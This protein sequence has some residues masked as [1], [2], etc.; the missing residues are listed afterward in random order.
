M[1]GFSPRAFCLPVALFVLACS[2][3]KQQSANLISP[4]I[5]IQQISATPTAARHVSG[6]LPVAFRVEVFNNSG[7]PLTLTR[8]R[9]ESVGEGAYNLLSSSQ[10]FDARI[11][12]D[13]GVS[14]EFWTSA[15]GQN[16]IMGN[17]GPVTIRGIAYFD[18]PVGAFQKIFI[19]Q[20]NDIGRGGSRN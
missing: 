15:I 1:R 10:A 4:D 6:P 12:P 2:A 20:V 5:R 8:V 7:E 3:N 17:N 13:R 14:V 11:A 9:V 16:T 18:S 19:Q